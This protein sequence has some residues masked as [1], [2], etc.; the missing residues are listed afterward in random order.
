MGCKV[1]DKREEREFTV[2]L[3]IHPHKQLRKRKNLENFKLTFGENNEIF[4]FFHSK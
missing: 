1:E 2:V 4:T 3:K